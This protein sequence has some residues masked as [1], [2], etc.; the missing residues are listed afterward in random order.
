MSVNF[1]SACNQGVVQQVQTPNR[2]PRTATINCRLELL[3][4]CP[5]AHCSAAQPASVLQMC[6]LIHLVMTAGT[7][8]I[9]CICV[10]G[11]SLWT[12]LPP[13]RSAAHLAG[14]PIKCHCVAGLLN[15]AELH[16]GKALVGIHV[17]ANHRGTQ[18]TAST[19]RH[20][21][22]QHKQECQQQQAGA[23]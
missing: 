14:D 15:T 20:H 7:G 12:P 21:H 8:V 1:T 6:L 3:A 11:R 19:N 17:A 16:K 4:G 18:R 9:Q 23:G 13:P 22:L 5:T 2:G 10:V